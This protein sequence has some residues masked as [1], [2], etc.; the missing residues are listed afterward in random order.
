VIS[1]GM[2]C[3]N[4][5]LV[6][7]GNEVKFDEDL[8]EVNGT[9][10]LM[11]GEV[12]DVISSFPLVKPYIPKDMSQGSNP[13][14][15]F[16][17]SDNSCIIEI[18]INAGLLEENEVVEEI[19]VRF[20]VTNP[21]E[22][23]QKALQICEDISIELNTQIIDM[24]LKAVIDLAN[25]LVLVKSKRAFEEKRARFYKMYNLPV[26]TW[27]KPMHCGRALFDELRNQ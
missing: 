16:F 15:Y 11:F 22:T 7:K 6:P 18:E 24:R 2:E 8:L 9:N 5:L 19:S 17:Y 14:C 10:K 20:A 21:I 12:S 1:L 27:A 23:F 26:N 3:F 13:K 25:D 4:F